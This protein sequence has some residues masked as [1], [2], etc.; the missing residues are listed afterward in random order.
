MKIHPT[1]IISEQ[2]KLGT[3]VSVG[4]FTIIEDDVIIYDNTE[5]H[6][7][8]F[9]ARGS[10]IGESCRIFKGAVIGNTPQD[11]KF[12]E[13]PTRTI[14][15]K[16]NTIRE[17][18]TIHKGTTATGITSTGENCLLMAYTHIAHDCHIGKNVIFANSTQLGGHVTIQDWSI[19]GGGTLV[20]QFS[21]IGCH[22]MIQGGSKVS[23]DV[24]PYTLVGKE[25]LKVE[26]LN[27]IGLRRRG[28]S[29]EQIQ[30]I[31][32]FYRTVFYSGLNNTDGIR[33]Y[34]NAST[35]L[36]P[37]VKICIDFITNSQRG[38]VR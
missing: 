13:A 16:N 22:T 9:I 11:L 29:Q 5:I 25:P 20:H 18:V 28:F 14:I 19:L 21:S 37:E 4:P 26:G 8:V 10:E 12:I 30:E 2:A 17:Y 24:P 15:G 7:H 33:A 34:C 6:S 38:V 35:E 32:E 27:K 23:K 36:T 31:E 1:A 3:N